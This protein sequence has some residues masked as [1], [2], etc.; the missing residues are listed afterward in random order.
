[1]KKYKYSE[2]RRPFGGGE[3]LKDT[4]PLRLGDRVKYV[5]NNHGERPDNPLWGGKFGKVLGTVYKIWD[6]SSLSIGV[7]WDNDH[8]NGYN[9]MDLERV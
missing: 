3:M 7:S 5:S 4:S 8:H 1:M 6:G 9:K 2:V